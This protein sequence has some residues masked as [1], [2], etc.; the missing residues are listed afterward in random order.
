M[1]LIPNG[2]VSKLKTKNIEAAVDPRAIIIAEAVNFEFFDFIVPTNFH[3]Q[4]IR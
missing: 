1:T 3:Q 4:L 2:I